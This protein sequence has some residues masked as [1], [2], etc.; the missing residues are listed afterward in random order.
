MSAS[1]KEALARGRHLSR[2]VNAYLTALDE[3]KPKRGRKR[4]PDSIAKRLAAIDA[5][6]A[7]ASPVKR[8]QLTQERLD[9][10]S[11]L[12]TLKNAKNDSDLSRLEKDFVGV[13]KEY[14]EAQGITRAAWRELGVAASV[15]K[16]AGI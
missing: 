10:K 2:T 1:H 13:A 5:A 6:L 14:S 11:E 3:N 8:L 7:S 9:L 15:L 4:T 12:A 16:K